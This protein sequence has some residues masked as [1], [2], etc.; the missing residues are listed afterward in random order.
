MEET[1]RPPGKL[2]ARIVREQAAISGVLRI[3]TEP[4]PGPYSLVK[5]RL[6]EENLT[7]LDRAGSRA[8]R[9]A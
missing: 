1:A 8:R 9:G 7:P 5:V 6:R 3:E 2:A 4:I